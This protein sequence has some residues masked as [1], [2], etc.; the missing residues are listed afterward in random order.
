MMPPPLAN[1]ALSLRPP[2]REAKPRTLLPP[3][4][5]ARLTPNE[6]I[7]MQ[8]LLGG[9]DLTTI[10]WCLKRDMRTISSHKQRAMGKLALT[11]NAMLY[12]LAALLSPPLPENITERR[13]LLTLREQQVLNA[14]LDGHG[15]TNIAHLRGRSVK[16]VSFQK[17]LLMQKLGITNEVELFALAPFRARALLAHWSGWSEFE[18]KA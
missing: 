14:L 5:A 3:Q 12:A 8:A 17:R 15:V 1:N 18:L 13:Q 16:T 2:E 11:S 9:Q 7:I 10:A 6:R 4:L